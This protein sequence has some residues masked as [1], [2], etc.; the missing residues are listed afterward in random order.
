MI[1]ISAAMSPGSSGSPVFNER[2][3]VIGVASGQ[4]FGDAPSLEF[5]GPRCGCQGPPLQK[6]STSGIALN[7]RSVESA[8]AN[9]TPS[10]SSFPRLRCCLCCRRVH[11]SF[12][13]DQTVIQSYPN[14]A[15]TYLSAGLIYGQLELYHEAIAAFGKA[16]DLDPM[17]NSA[18]YYLAWTLFQE[19]N[20]D[21]AREAC[22]KAGESIARLCGRLALPQSD[23]ARAREWFGSRRSEPPMRCL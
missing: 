18:M 5:R 17:S 2:G 11:R 15:A 7:R 16:L 23:S 20:Y 22:P 10:D 12:E 4:F 21:T 14:I 9:K 8:T 6:D 19:R 1:Q 13:T 3:E